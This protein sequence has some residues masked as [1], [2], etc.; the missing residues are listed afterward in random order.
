MEQGILCMSFGTLH[1]MEL[2]SHGQHCCILEIGGCQRFIDF[3]E[4][5]RMLC[6]GEGSD[7]SPCLLN[8][9]A[10]V[11]ILCLFQFNHKHACGLAS[12]STYQLV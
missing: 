3:L 11:I 7:W 12:I 5:H 9:F 1:F 8:L 4:I 6:F 10:T 2:T